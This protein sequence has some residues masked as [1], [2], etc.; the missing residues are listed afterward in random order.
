MPENISDKT[1]INKNDIITIGNLE[2]KFQIE[3]K[4]ICQLKWLT[5]DQQNKFETI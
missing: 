2:K 1:K 5:F 4:M 3:H